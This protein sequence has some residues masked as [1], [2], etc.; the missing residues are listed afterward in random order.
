[1][2]IFASLL[3]LDEF[4]TV[5]ALSEGGFYCPQDKALAGWA[6]L[7]RAAEAPKA[8]NRLELYGTIG[9]DWW[10]GTEITGASVS[11]ALKDMTGDIE[12]VI[13]SPGGDYFEG[14]AIY[15]HLR[16]HSGRV[17]VKIISLAASAASVIA[18]A[19]D[20]IQIADNASFMIHNTWTVAVG[21]RATFAKVAATMGQFDA[22]MARL[23]ARRAGGKESDMSALMDAE[24]WFTGQA[25]ID[26]GFADG[27]L[28]DAVQEADE[29][30][31]AAQR[32]EI[33]AAYALKKQDPKLTRKDCRAL[34]ADL[35]GGTP[36][37]ALPRETPFD[38]DFAASA[39]KL[40]DSLKGA[41]S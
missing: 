30:A 2:K 3:A 12:V 10:T 38:A 26:A 25:A 29:T 34:L 31:N 15:N 28:T 23:Y 9:Y 6:P 11:R 19:G 18:M 16:Q 35:K 36:R 41:N 4:P 7:A 37:A 33:R 13:N 27:L 22:A 32:A 14:G 20:E 8:A 21:D 39:Q 24:T 17:T 5:N 1:M 40:M